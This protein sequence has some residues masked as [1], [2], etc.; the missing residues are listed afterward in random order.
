MELVDAD[1]Y[2]RGERKGLISLARGLLTAPG[3]IAVA[4]VTPPPAVQP[5]AT[6]P[7][8]PVPTPQL[9]T[10]VGGGVIAGTTLG[11]GAVGVTTVVPT[12]VAPGIDANSNPSTVAPTTPPTAAPD[13]S[14][15]QPYAWSVFDETEGQGYLNL[16]NLPVVPA[17]Q[18]LQLWVKSADSADYR[19]VGEVPAQFYGSSGSLYYKLPDSTATPTDILITREPRNPAATKPT[20]PRIL[21]G[22]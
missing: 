20:G 17:D 4:P 11:N 13:A 2:A 15:A 14:V 6:V 9:Q 22:P 5:S 12:T 8:T 3:I 19:P 1:S 16:Y 21:H 18:A 7:P 10:A